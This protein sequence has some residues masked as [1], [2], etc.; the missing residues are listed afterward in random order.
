MAKIKEALSNKDNGMSSV[1]DGIILMFAIVFAAVLMFFGIS[2][3]TN[4]VKTDNIT[5]IA[6]QCIIS[7]ETEGGMTTEIT[8]E[9]RA[10]LEAAGCT[11][12]SFSDS[13]Q[14]PV[15]FGNTITLHLK[16]NIPYRRM[17]M[18]GISIAVTQTHTPMDIVLTST[19]KA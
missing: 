6:R 11:D 4:L 1:G 8:N 14:A 18:A 17:Q 13:S 12:V 9:T 16:A 10:K 2:N 15:L 19:S 3:Y 5:M 7:M